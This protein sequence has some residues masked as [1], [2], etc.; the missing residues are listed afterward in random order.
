[1]A[2]NYSYFPINQI[3]LK[4]L[5]DYCK[6]DT[7]NNIKEITV[8][9]MTPRLTKES[10]ETED[11]MTLPKVLTTKT[12]LSNY[13]KEKGFTFSFHENGKIT[14]Y[15]DGVKI[16]W[17]KKLDPLYM[18]S[19]LGGKDS[20]NDIGLNGYLFRSNF[21]IDDCKNWLGC[22]EILQAI[23]SKFRGKNICND[24]F[25]NQVNYLVS[26]KVPV[27]KID[28]AEANSGSNITELLVKYSVNALAHLINDVKEFKNPVIMLERN[29]TVPNKDILQINTLNIERHKVYV[30]D[31]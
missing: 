14:S 5:M 3:S 16:D 18:E 31:V 21:V 25:N 4:E 15:K 10:V 30:E 11:L 17:S 23:D 12:E 19:R 6:S 7:L 22:P 28:F 2:E 26:F 9:H 20:R 29:Y 27:N 8:S 1:M 13:L 24:F